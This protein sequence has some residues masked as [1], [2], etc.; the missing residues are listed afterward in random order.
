MQQ[1]L[2]ANNIPDEEGPS[3]NELAEEAGGS[4]SYHTND[5]GQDRNE[6]RV[7]ETGNGEEV[8]YRVNGDLHGEVLPLTVE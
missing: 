3:A 6:E 2:S 1:V 7:V 4:L 5:E 8:L